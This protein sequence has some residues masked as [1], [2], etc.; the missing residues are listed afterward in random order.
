MSDLSLVVLMVGATCGIVG[1]FIGHTV[2]YVQA[3]RKAGTL[4]GE[5]T[6]SI[7]DARRE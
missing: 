5:L 1:Y 7:K 2:G 6:Q 3:T 4:I